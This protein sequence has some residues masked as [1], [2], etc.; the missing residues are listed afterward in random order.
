VNTIFEVARFSDIHVESEN[1]EW[2]L[3]KSRCNSG[4]F[5]RLTRYSLCC[6]ERF[7]QLVVQIAQMRFFLR[8]REFFTAISAAFSTL[9]V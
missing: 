3:H 4:A 6:L 7:A 8:R 5:F 1:E 2:K 9:S